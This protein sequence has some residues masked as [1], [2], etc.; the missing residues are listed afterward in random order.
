MLGVDKGLIK[1]RIDAVR[2]TI[3]RNITIYTL[4]ETECL[5]CVASGLF[6]PSTNSS[7][8]ITCPQCHGLY[9]LEGVEEQ[10]IL[11]RVHWVSNDGITATPGGKYFLGDATITV[12]P[13]YTELLQK[14]QNEAGKVV[15][16]QT[17]MQIVRVNPM[18][19]PEVNRVRAVLK[20]M[21]KR[22]K[23]EL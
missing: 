9:W 6:D 17:D 18:G 8:N 10:E 21:G 23:V 2:E 22:R 3:G 7:F 19:A 16:D 11:A 14:T 12:D 1:D 15:V 13:C 20:S 5:E 4:K